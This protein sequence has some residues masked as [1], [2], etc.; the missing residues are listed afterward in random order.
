M[1]NTSNVFCQVIAVFTFPDTYTVLRN[2]SDDEQ[3]LAVWDLDSS[4]AY[5]VKVEGVTD[6]N[7][8]SASTSS[9]RRDLNQC[10]L[11]FDLYSL[12]CC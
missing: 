3:T 1:K 12:G 7:V 9:K 2:N 4:Y 10:C 6:D 5:S 11:P 8:A